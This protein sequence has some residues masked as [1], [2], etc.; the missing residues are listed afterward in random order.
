MSIGTRLIEEERLRQLNELGRSIEIDQAYK[1]S[2]LGMAAICYTTMAG[3]GEIT[4]HQLRA[5]APKYWPW[6]FSSWKPSNGDSCKERIR[7]LQK[8]GALIAAEIDYLAVKACDQ[9]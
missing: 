2:T 7:E 3:S 8:A 6:G 5:N 9:H 1:P 4:R